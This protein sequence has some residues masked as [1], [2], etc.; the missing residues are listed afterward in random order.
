MNLGIILL[1]F[2]SLH[3]AFGSKSYEIF[4]DSLSS[5]L[6]KINRKGVFEERN[7]TFRSSEK[8]GNLWNSLKKS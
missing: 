8:G 5:G 6:D 1:V 4:L 7:L 3:L 2:N